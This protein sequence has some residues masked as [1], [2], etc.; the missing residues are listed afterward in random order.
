VAVTDLAEPPA[1]TGHL[2]GPLHPGGVH[3]RLDGQTPCSQR[4]ARPRLA[5]VDATQGAVEFANLP[6]A[7]PSAIGNGQY[8]LA[9]VDLGAQTIQIQFPLDPAVFSQAFVPFASVQDK[10]FNGVR[11]SD[12]DGL[13]P[14]IRGVSIVTSAASPTGGRRRR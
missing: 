12:A 9:T 6:N 3:L 14:T 11:L 2:R 7:D 1:W 5:T 4:P 13:L 10:P 8:G